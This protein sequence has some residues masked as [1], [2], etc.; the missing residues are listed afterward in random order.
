MSDYY[1]SD[2][3]TNI[4]LNKKLDWYKELIDQ[5]L[6][7][8][9]VD[10][11][12]RILDISHYLCESLG[13]RK[14]EMIGEL[15]ENFIMTEKNE[16]SDIW[17]DRVS[18]SV[19]IKFKCKDETPFFTFSQIS[20]L[21]DGKDDDQ[22][23]TVICKDINDRVL[24]KKQSIKDELTQLY[25]KHYFNM[26]FEKEINRARRDE[27]VFV[28]FL[29]EMDHFKTYNEAYGYKQGELV[30]VKIAEILL[31]SLKRGTARSLEL[32]NLNLQGL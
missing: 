10:F 25:N 11:G 9:N 29:L 4:T 28:L 13:Y 7:I 32:V 5:N 2:K 15:I 24:L 20:L 19:E 8:F 3:A 14:E 31:R 18:T 21:F 30:L 1:A 22:G 27:E 23:H 12:G 26:I 17:S 6:L 16:F